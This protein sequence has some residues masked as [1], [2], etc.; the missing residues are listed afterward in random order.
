MLV[1]CV[2]WTFPQSVQAV[3]K[4]KPLPELINKFQVNE[5][6]PIVPKKSI[7]AKK[8]NRTKYTASNNGSDQVQSHAV[9]RN[10]SKEEIEN[11]IRKYS[12]QYGIDSDTPRCIAFHESGYNQFSANRSSTAKGVFQYLNSTWRG[13]DE[14]KDGR[15][16]FD[17]E[18]NVR[19]AIK[20]MASRRSTQP[21][22]VKSK[23]PPITKN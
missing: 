13:T 3:E 20:Y 1:A 16:V 12:D 19:A 5:L 18:A 10:Y 7:R 15:S 22:A 9:R 6:Q 11:L 2:M 23:C 4:Q 14:G 17:A 21:W 8:A